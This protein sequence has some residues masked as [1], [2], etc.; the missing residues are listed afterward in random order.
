MAKNK[1]KSLYSMRIAIISPTFPPY[2]G[3]IGNV[4]AFNARE[5]AKLGHEVEIFTPKYK[6]VEEEIK[7]LKI[8]RIKPL[9]KYGNA[10]FLP[11]LHW[12]LKDFEIIHLHYPFF[13]GAETI[14]LYRRKIKKTG[15]KIVLHYHMDVVGQGIFKTIF[16]FHK[17]IL[18][19]KIIKLADKVIVT[20]TDYGKNSDLA[21]WMFKN[22]K[23]FYELPNGVD[24][25]LFFPA[26]KDEALIKKNNINP[27]DKVVLF[28]GGLDQAHYFKGVE[29]LVEAMSRLRDKNYNWKLVI[30]GK[31][32]LV[33]HYQSLVSQLRI[34]RQVIFSG[35]VPSEDLPKYYNLADVVVLPSID[36]S[37]AFGLTLIEAMACAKPVVA[38]NLVGVR[39]VV[40]D[41]TNGLLTEPKNIDDLATKINYLLTN[42]DVASQF[43][44][45]GRKKVEE[46]YDWGRIGDELERLYKEILNPNI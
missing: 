17:K 38:S 37:E 9:L 30:V 19:P 43:G 39:S 36:K 34:D 6:E 35:Y 44:Q 7:D 5:L 24:T 12:M 32:E 21:K 42:S 18:L 29:Y 27:D 4:A 10:A 16:S 15:A 28:V 26:P 3:G 23:K 20:S 2:P 41:Q 40:D 1:L 11:A 45:A 46:K 31:G 25:D 8:N 33:K 13:G 22:P 14:W